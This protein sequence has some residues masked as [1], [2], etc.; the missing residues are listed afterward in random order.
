MVWGAKASSLNPS[1]H[2]VTLYWG[3]VTGFKSGPFNSGSDPR[4]ETYN[5][6]GARR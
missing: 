6:C 5:W 4:R 2:L 3:F 1:G